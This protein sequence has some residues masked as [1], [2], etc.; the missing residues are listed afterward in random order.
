MINNDGCKTTRGPNTL[1]SPSPFVSVEY[2]MFF[3]TYMLCY[4]MYTLI[5]FSTFS[6]KIQHNN[7]T[8]MDN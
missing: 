1:V 6:H 5:S 7:L 2:I 8:G 3:L 4:V